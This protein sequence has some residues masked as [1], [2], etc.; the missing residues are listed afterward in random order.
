MQLSTD[1]LSE[2]YEQ[3]IRQQTYGGGI[4][5]TENVI[6]KYDSDELSESQRHLVEEHFS[7]CPLCREDYISLGR[8]GEWFRR[9]EHV[10]LG[11]IAAKGT[12]A[13]VLP[14]AR[15]PSVGMLYR[16][17]A[18]EIPATPGGEILLAEMDQHVRACPDCTRLAEQFRQALH[19]P[20]LS[21]RDVAG[22][23]AL[24]VLDRMRGLFDALAA[25][26]QGAGAPAFVRGAPGFR[27]VDAPAVDAPVLSV[28]GKVV[29]ESDGQPRLCRFEVIQADI[30][31]DGFLTVD[32]SATDREF[33]RRDDQQYEAKLS[34]QTGGLCLVLP[35]VIIDDQGRA[36]FTG[37]LPK[38]V[39]VSPLPLSCLDITVQPAS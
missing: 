2:L 29:V 3:L 27:S 18:K 36:T 32:L 35:E 22:N 38:A 20:K 19:A 1:Q 21:L 6:V 8:A 11:G 33:H 24:T 17:I 15:C 4:C 10:I 9:Y 30:H 5:P 28:D 16:Y 39:A 31:S 14:W 23:V 7:Q 26:V 13:G 34:I 37:M 12:A 25:A